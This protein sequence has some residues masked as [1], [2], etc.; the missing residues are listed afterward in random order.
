MDYTS[1]PP[2]V[3]SKS[4]SG[5]KMSCWK[6]CGLS[7]C[8]PYLNTLLDSEN[9]SKIVVLSEHWVWPYDLHKLHE[10][11]DDLDAVGKSDIRLTED[12]EGSRGCGGIGILWHKSI[13]AS[14]IQDITSD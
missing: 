9:G 5:M 14:P 3:K 10:A 7:S 13:D 11:N 12:R 6:C 8:L 4:R 1:S 2:M